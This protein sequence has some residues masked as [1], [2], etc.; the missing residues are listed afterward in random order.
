MRLSSE[1]LQGA[2]SGCG[3]PIFFLVAKVGRQ[4]GSRLTCFS[5]LHPWSAEP[6]EIILEG[7]GKLLKG[8]WTKT[9]LDSYQHLEKFTSLL[10][11]SGKRREK[12]LPAAKKA[13]GAVICPPLKC[14]NS[15]RL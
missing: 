12:M 8:D 2:A 3:H 11:F 9:H 7:G 15:I 10:R 5:L 1:H 14:E 13:F 6:A 4:A